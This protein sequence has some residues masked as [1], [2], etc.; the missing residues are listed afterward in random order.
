MPIFTKTADGWTEIG[1]G[2][3][4]ASAVIGGHNG[5]TVQLNVSI[6]GETYDIY[7][8]TDDT[9]TDLSLNVDTP[10]LVDVLVL[11]G[12]GRGGNQDNASFTYASGG[13]GAGGLYTRV[14][15]YIPKANHP[16]SVGAGTPGIDT[17]N[18][19]TMPLGG[20]SYINNLFIVPGGGTGGC[21]TAGGYHAAANGM[22]GASGGGGG[23]GSTGVSS[24][25]PG[26]GNG[27]GDGAANG[28][29]GGGG[30]ESAGSAGASGVGGAGGA[31]KDLSSFIGAAPGTLV[32]A[33]GGGG[34]GST[35]GAGG[36]SVGGAGA[37]GTTAN[38]NDALSNTGSG[39]G[40]TVNGMGGSGSSGIVIVRVK[41]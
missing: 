21:L 5:A 2:G 13:G 20:A 32:L 12:G 31:G 27:G 33:G 30:A 36:S 14:N 6:D 3:G 4:V 9:A 8:F 11:G 28:G 40:G 18:H 22:D 29:G 17:G 39:G 35:G 26:L 34:S 24:G 15:A 37:N 38:G 7:T 25:I 41:V 23:Q 10:G 16:V 19:V 1:T